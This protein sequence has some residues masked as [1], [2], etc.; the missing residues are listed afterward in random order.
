MVGLIH[1]G[2]NSI[3]APTG[4]GKESPGKLLKLHF[5]NCNMGLSRG[6]RIIK[7]GPDLSKEQAHT[8]PGPACH[9]CPVCVV[10]FSVCVC[11]CVHTWVNVYVDLHAYGG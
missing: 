11:N 5:F 10:F 4:V 6:L 9:H 7:I 1:C 3:T 2:A 8:G